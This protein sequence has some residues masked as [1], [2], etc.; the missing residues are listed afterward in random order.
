MTEPEGR[1]ALLELGQE[2]LQ[3]F[4][5]EGLQE[6]AYRAGQLYE[7]LYSSLVWDYSQMTNLPK[8]LREKLTTLAPLPKILALEEHTSTDGLTTKTLFQLEDGECIEAVLM[9]HGERHTACLSAQ[10]GCAIGCPF[11]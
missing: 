1:I 5:V 10:A 3:R 2:E 9:G 11:C 6:P 4:L 7:W 8:P